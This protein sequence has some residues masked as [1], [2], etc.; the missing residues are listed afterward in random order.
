MNS[1]IYKKIEEFLKSNKKFCIKLG[2]DRISAVLNLL[3]NPQNNLKII[4]VAGTN[5]KGSVCSITA[6]ILQDAG[7]NV[8]LYTSPHLY[9]YNE[10]FKIND[11]D[12]SDQNLFSYLFQIE[13]IASENNIELTEFELLTAIA[14]KY[15]SDNRVDFAV[16]ETGLG[17]RFDA[18][19]VIQKPI[20]TAITSISIDHKDRLG[21]TVEQIA[22][23]KAGIIKKNVPVFVNSDNVAF[24][25]FEKVAME[26]NSR[27]IVANKKIDIAFE[28]NINYAI[29]DNEKFEF[30]LWGLHQKQ[31]LSL[32]LSIT[33]YL[34]C[35]NYKINISHIKNALKNVFIPA[36][37]QYDEKN[38]RI[39]D[40]AHN[41]DA[42]KILKKNLQFYFP[43]KNKI[44]VYGSL[45]TKEYEKIV[46]ILFENGDSVFLLNNFDNS[47]ALSPEYIIS[48]FNK[49]NIKFEIFNKTAN[50]LN[51]ISKDSLIIITGSFYMIGDLFSS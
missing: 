4:H 18:V 46:N 8:A 32:A 41:V 45:T 36:R 22:F 40:G 48:I 33:E 16:M 5:G 17:G 19:N 2:L 7:Y 37:F 51:F 3:G 23:E 13:K 30:S 1:L 42:A 44:W 15:F 11:S 28:N 38:N 24:S 43:N 34:Q 21:D 20:I 10:R 26:K 50:T 9:K 49:K 12:I 31:N 39:L 35:L 25:T 29:F 14:F 47:L 27:L 6:K